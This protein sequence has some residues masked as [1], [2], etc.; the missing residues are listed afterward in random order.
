MSITLS[1]DTETLKNQFYSLGTPEDIA[2]MLE[3]VS[4]IVAHREVNAQEA[5]PAHEPLPT[6]SRDVPFWDVFPSNLYCHDIS[7][8]SEGPSWGEIR[9]GSSRVEDLK[10]YIGTIGNFDVINEWADYISFSRTGSLRDDNGI[11][12]V[13]G[14]CVDVTTRTVTAL[15]ISMITSSLYLQDLAALDGLPDMVTWGSN[16]ISRTVFWFGEGIAASVNIL[17]QN[18]MLEYGQI[19]FVVYFPYQ[20]V[21]GFEGRW[22]YNRTNSENPVG[23]DR[24]YEPPPSEEQNPFDFEAMVATITAQPSRTPTPT[25]GPPSSTSTATPTP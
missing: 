23:G 9:I 16:N 8:P 6:L 7:N 17:E 5:N 12:S 11:P 2:K 15:S 10:N 3:V 21:E 13:I 14:G 20:Q 22:P 1:S 18:R 25:F 19:S 24:V 4:S